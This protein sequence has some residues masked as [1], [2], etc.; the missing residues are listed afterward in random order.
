MARALLFAL[1]LALPACWSPRAFT[2]RERV[3]AAGPGGVPAALYAIPA[4]DAGEPSVAELRVWSAGA[5]ARF[6]A[7]DREVTELHVGFELENNGATPLQLDL[8]AL[9]CEELLL[10]GLLQPH[11]QPV[12]MDGDGLA[13]PGKT[14]RVDVLFEPATNR[15]RDIDS[16]QVRF[17]VRDGERHAL[18]QVAPFG[19]WQRPLAGDPLW[20]G[21][22]GWGWYGGYGPGPGPGWGPGWGPGFGWGWRYGW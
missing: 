9:T 15:P 17:S 10:D 18:Q 20:Y 21:S 12:R 5:K 16:F 3:D 6:T 8:G 14:A 11:L 7:D 4:A 2:P 19:P 22:A 1:L 13:A